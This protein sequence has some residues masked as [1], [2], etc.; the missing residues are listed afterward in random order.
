MNTIDLIREAY[1]RVADG[2]KRIDLED[3]GVK[4]KAYRVGTIIRI[5]INENQTT[6][7]S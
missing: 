2:M 1:T 4:V 5:D 7:K 6:T 3:E